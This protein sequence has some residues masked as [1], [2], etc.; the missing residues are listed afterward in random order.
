MTLKTPPSTMLR[1]WVLRRWVPYAVFALLCVLTLAA[2]WYVSV[3]T[4]VRIAAAQLAA[5]NEIS[6]VEFRAFVAGLQLRERYPALEAIGFAPRI[7]R[8]RLEAFRR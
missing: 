1:R 4:N 3:A 5:S 2:A 8:P 6:H 7:A